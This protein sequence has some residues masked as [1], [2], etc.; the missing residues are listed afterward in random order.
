MPEQLLDKAELRAAIR[1]L[2][3]EERR[4]VLNFLVGYNPEALA[5]ALEWIHGERE[6]SGEGGGSDG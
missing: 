4:E 3:A 2:T 6:A 5:S 1:S